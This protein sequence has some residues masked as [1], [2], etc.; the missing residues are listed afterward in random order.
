MEEQCGQAREDLRRW[1]WEIDI[2]WKGGYDGKVV[3]AMDLDTK[4]RVFSVEKL[5]ITRQ[6]ADGG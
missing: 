5:G 3:A 6:S 2:G 1:A 4:R